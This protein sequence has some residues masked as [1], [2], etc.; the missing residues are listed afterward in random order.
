MF[1]ILG[2]KETETRLVRKGKATHF[3]TEKFV[4]ELPCTNDTFTE[5]RD[6]KVGNLTLRVTPKGSRTYYYRRATTKKFMK[7]IG[8]I[9][10]V[11]LEQARLIATNVDNNFEE[12]SKDKIDIRIP[13]CRYLKDTGFYPHKKLSTDT[14]A[15]EA[16]PAGTAQILSNENKLLKDKI[17]EYQ[18]V[19]QKINKELARAISEKE[20]AYTALRECW[21]A[22]VKFKREVNDEE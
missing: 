17:K 19:N 1:K 12:F 11:T 22:L 14:T 9:Y 3:F 18:E 4:R 7:C 10:E 2:K 6:L 5:V 8:T 21:N 16:T 13:L 20:R 15:V